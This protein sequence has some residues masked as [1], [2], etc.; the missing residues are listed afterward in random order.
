MSTERAPGVATEATP[1]RSWLCGPKSVEPICSSVSVI[2][3]RAQGPWASVR[4]TSGLPPVTS[5]EKSAAK[6]TRRSDERMGVTIPAAGEQRPCPQ[7]RPPQAAGPAPRHRRT[8]GPPW[9]GAMRHRPGT[10]PPGPQVGM[11]PFA[12]A[13]RPPHCGV[14]TSQASMSSCR[15][16]LSATHA[17]RYA[18]GDSCCWSVRGRRRGYARRTKAVTRNN[19]LRG[20]MTKRSKEIATRAPVSLLQWA[21]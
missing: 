17:A 19:K 9:T 4:A 1:S 3:V 8:R 21:S 11:R 5:D 10:Q 7:A 2:E 18:R 14:E 13:A 20:I 12:I 16:S 6:C 15:L